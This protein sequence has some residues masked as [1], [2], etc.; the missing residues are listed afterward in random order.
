MGEFFSLIR[1]PAVAFLGSFLVV[2]GWMWWP[3]ISKL[4]PGLSSSNSSA[5]SGAPS[6]GSGGSWF[7]DINRVGRPENAAVVRSCI[8]GVVDVGGDA[9][10]EPSAA[11]F[12][13]KGDPTYAA[14]TAA[15]GSVSVLS[16][17]NPAVGLAA[18]WGKLATCI[19]AQDDRALCDPDNR[20]AAVEA[21]EKFLRFAAQADLARPLISGSDAQMIRNLGDRVSGALRKQGVT[22]RLLRAISA[23][24]AASHCPTSRGSWVKRSKPAT[25]ARSVD[26]PADDRRYSSLE[27]KIG[28][29]TS[30]AN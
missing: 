8:F 6:V 7:A 28:K 1:A 9:R 3:Q 29:S 25:S 16:E 13:L 5:S 20:A 22:A 2:G 19:Y 27:E 4:I 23:A 26:A 24:S 12:I 21:T 10:I 30:K 18:K 15:A 17:E 11:Y 14:I